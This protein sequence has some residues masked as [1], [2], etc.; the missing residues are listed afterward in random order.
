MPDRLLTACVALARWPFDPANARV[1][2]VAGGLINDTFRVEAEGRQLALQHVAPIFEPAM[3]DD[4]DRVTRH[5]AAKGVGTPRVVRSRNDRTHEIVDGGI[6]RVLTW[7]DGVMHERVDR[8]G[9]ARAAGAALGRFHAALS[10]YDE[11][12]AA[13]RLG[14]HD[15]D[16]H[17]EALKDALTDHAD[18]PR[19]AAVAPVGEAI[20]AHPR[21]AL[22][23]TPE[24]V[25]HGDPKITNLVFD[26]ATHAGKAWI[27][28]DTVGPMALPLE[29]GDALRSWCNRAGE[30]LDTAALDLELFEAALTG[31]AGTAGPVRDEEWAAFVPATETIALELAARFCRDALEESYFGW[32]PARYPSASH[33]HLARARSQLALARSV[34]AL[35]AEA[36]ARLRRAR[37]A[38]G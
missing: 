21:P 31:Y 7:I 3:C 20:F 36:E 17:L 34:A 10:D 26:G 37:A 5:L 1:H 25:V 14:V 6:W 12:F 4:V 8:A 15:T 28:L 22:P 16:R 32:S 2:Q 30:D 19:W 35:R 33:H 18:H 27:D 13:R 9:L 29:L 38:A 24:R 11:P 23:N